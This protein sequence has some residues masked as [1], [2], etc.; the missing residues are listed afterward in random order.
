LNVRV[1]SIEVMVSRLPLGQGD[2]QDQVHRVSHIDLIVVDVRSDEGHVGTGISHTSGVG[3]AG[4]AGLL[5]ELAPEVIGRA[6][7]PGPLWDWSWKYLH[8]C[9]GGGVTTLALAALDLAYWD[10]VGKKAGLPVVDLLG[11]RQDRVPLYGSGINLNMTI[12]QLVD[13]A[14]QWRARGY[15]SIK[16]K[17][18]KESLAEDVERVAAVKAAVPDVG[19]MVDA[20]QGWTLTE[21][22]RRI[23][24]LEQFS[25]VWVEEPLLVDD[26][27]AHAQLA[28]KVRCPIALGENLYTIWQFKELMALGAIDYVQADI[29]R[30][31]GIT[32]YLRVADLAAAYQL[33][34]APHFIMEL[35]AEVAASVRNLYMVEDTAGGTL[36]ELGA[37]TGDADIA[38]GWYP[39]GRR[40]GLG[41]EWDRGWLQQHRAGALLASYG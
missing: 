37:V 3:A 1:E 5:G 34:M 24:A 2:W 28:G 35:S 10:L 17:V 18:G 8:D 15:R 4:I 19:L 27:T 38:D 11:R 33:P 6:V 39:V 26:P 23:R 22:V 9:G 13:Q 25:L 21:A 12:D 14:Q 41:V 20:N 36:R 29:A 32:P 31:G 40:P 30:V 7:Q 16:I